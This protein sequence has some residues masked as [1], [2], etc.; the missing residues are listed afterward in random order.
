MAKKKKVSRK[1]LLRE[2]DAFIQAANS[3]AEWVKEHQKPVIASAIAV[4]VAIVGTWLGLIYTENRDTA[5]SD[6]LT[7]AMAVFDAQVVAEEADPTA[8]PPI[9]ATD[10]EKWAAAT[11]AFKKLENGSGALSSIGTFY[12]ADIAER[13]GDLAGAKQGFR[14]ALT[15]LSGQDTLYFLAVERLAYLQEKE[16]KAAD[17]LT[18]LKKLQSKDG[19]YADYASFH[20][21]RI[22]LAGGEKDKARALLE[23][24]ESDFPQSS[25]RE[26]VKERLALLG[27]SAD[28]G[29]AKAPT[30]DPA[31]PAKAEAAQK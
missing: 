5:A 27:R 1:E 19:F 9:F 23:R 7:Q 25:L 2:D 15:N 29:D 8:T 3:S 22:H 26:N 28:A 6:A 24:V 4:V 18:T 11:E 30:A 14:D 31:D 13:N 20:Q 12:L 16:G 21:A 10:D 17:A